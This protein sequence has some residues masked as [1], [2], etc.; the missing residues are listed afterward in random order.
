M[1]HPKNLRDEIFND[2]LDASQCCYQWCYQEVCAQSQCKANAKE[3]QE[4]LVQEQG[5]LNKDLGSKTKPEKKLQSQNQ[6][7]PSQGQ[8]KSQGLETQS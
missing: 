5:Q 7:E 6:G 4:K 2:Y 3:L 1:Q 8:N